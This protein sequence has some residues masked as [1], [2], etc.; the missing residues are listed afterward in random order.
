MKDPKPADQAPPIPQDGNREIAGCNRS[1]P[2]MMSLR[3]LLSLM[4]ERRIDV[5]LYDI[6]A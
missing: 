6:E 3:E 2:D 1:L 4:S 5:N